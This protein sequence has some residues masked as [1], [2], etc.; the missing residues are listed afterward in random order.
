MKKLFAALWVVAA[1]SSLSATAQAS[2]A[3]KEVRVGE[4]AKLVDALVLEQ[5]SSQTGPM[6]MT[7]TKDAVK[8]NIQKLS[9]VWLSRGPKWQSYT[10]NPEAKS[11]LIRD[12]ST[13]KDGLLELGAKKHLKKEGQFKLKDKGVH[14]TI[15]GYSCRKAELF[16]NPASPP[17]PKEPHKPYCCGYVWIADSFPAPKEL[18]EVMHNLVRVDVNKGM[19]LKFQTLKPGSYTSFQTSFETKSIVKAKQPASAFEPPTGYHTVKS[20][21]QLLMDDS[22]MDSDYLKKP[23]N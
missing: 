19:V 20:E 2:G 10:F 18:L 3:E 7:V 9:I 13:W 14:E 12:H 8:I 1:L 16:Q 6:T 21:I 22:S 15:A 17:R 23:V 4:K 11:I 5:S